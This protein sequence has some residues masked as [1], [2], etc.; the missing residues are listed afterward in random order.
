[1]ASPVSRPTVGSTG[2][3][4]PAHRWGWHRGACYGGSPA[5]DTG[6]PTAGPRELQ[7][8]LSQLIFN[9]YGL[10]SNSTHLAGTGVGGRWPGGLAVGEIPSGRDT[11]GRGLRADPPV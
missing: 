4:R 2:E 8:F 6:Q 9:T 7:G 1:M 5:T 10:R 3:R 11:F